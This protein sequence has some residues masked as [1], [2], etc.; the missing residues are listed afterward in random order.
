MATPTTGLP[1]LSVVLARTGTANGAS[2]IEVDVSTLLAAQTT[3]TWI[4]HEIIT[5]PSQT[6]TTSSSSSSSSSSRSSANS[7]AAQTR[8]TSPLPTN[9]T[10]SPEATNP[11]LS[12]GATAGIA[13]G[14]A[15]V[16]LILGLIAGFLIFRR[17]RDR[18]SGAHY[19]S[20][21]L[22][23]QEKPLRDPLSA[24]KL[25]LDQ[26]LLDPTPDAEIGTELGSL[27]QLL[28]QHV[29]G[30][31][32]TLPVF[33][34]VEALST[35]LVQLGLG[36]GGTMPANRLASLT[37]DPKSRYHAIQHIIA[38]VTFSSVS[39]DTVSP[40]SLLPQPVS[41]FVSMVPATESH[42]GNPEGEYIV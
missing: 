5:L 34:D 35:A 17:R 19:Q 24:D 36:Q 9:A 32:H 6:S 25:R 31:Y 3:L 7:S 41:S 11:G 39:F 16:G 37:L 23:S 4:H 1:T 15:A 27:A 33:Q 2:Y 28:Q 10:H 21:G 38:R 30:H 26:F 40:I 13:I 8:P 22:D 29:E 12:S 18:K 42:R 20:V 14:S